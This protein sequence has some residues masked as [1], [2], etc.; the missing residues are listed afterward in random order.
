MPKNL[1]ALERPK[2]PRDILLG[3]V[4]APVSIPFPYIPDISWL[5]RNYQGDTAFCGEH[6]GS[7]FKPI[8]D[9]ANLAGSPIER[10]SPRYGVIKLKDPN[11]PLYDGYAIDAGT[12]MPAI[13]KWLQKAG[14]ADFE[15]LEDDVTLAMNVYCDP[16]VVTPAIDANA[17]Q[18]LISS[19]A[20]GNTNFQ[21]LCQA[22][23]QNNAVILLIKCDDGFW[24]TSTPTF[25][26]PTY[27]HFVVAYGYDAEGIYVIDSAEPNNEF[28]LKH[29]LTQY[30]TPQ[31]F[32]E[33]GSAIDLPPVVKQALTSGQPVPASVTNALSTGQLSLAEQILNDI[34]AALSLIK[35]EI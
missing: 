22:I 7:H 11:S 10:K 25:T 17:A 9:F 26:T 35:Q 33:A 6:A 24:G 3:S 12:T 32:F 2:D 31:F 5:V 28:A 34:E 4:Q 15:P 19:Y 30:I 21:S 16:S 29:I 13:F 23:Y 14:A 8:L 20:F 27:G 1:G 18:S